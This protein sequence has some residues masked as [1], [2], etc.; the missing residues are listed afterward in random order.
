MT[1]KAVTMPDAIEVLASRQGSPYALVCIAAL[2]ASNAP[3]PKGTYPALARLK[4]HSGALVAGCLRAFAEDGLTG[5]YLWAEYPPITSPAMQAVAAQA[6]SELY[7][8]CFL[9]CA[10][11]IAAWNR[12]QIREVA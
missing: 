12:K 10:E 3:V 4:G 9:L 5:V 8:D 1:T 7:A 2:E 11:F 6:A